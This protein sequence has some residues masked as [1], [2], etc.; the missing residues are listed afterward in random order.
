MAIPEGCEKQFVEFYKCELSRSLWER[1]FLGPC[2]AEPC[3]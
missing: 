2:I 3:L 1:L